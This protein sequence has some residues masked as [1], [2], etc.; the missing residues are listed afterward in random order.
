MP[1]SSDGASIISEI[2]QIVKWIVIANTGLHRRNPERYARNLRE[3]DKLLQIVML[4]STTRYLNVRRTLSKSRTHLYRLPHLE[5]DHFIQEVRV[6][7]RTFACILAWLE[8]DPIFQNNSLNKQRPV[9]VQLACALHRLGHNGTGASLGMTARAMGISY[10][11]VVLYTQ[12]VIIATN[13]MSS[14]FLTWPDATERRSLALLSHERFGF[15]GCIGLSTDGTHIP[16]YQRPGLDGETYF[17]RKKCYSLNV[18]LTFDMHRSIRFVIAGWPGSVHDTRPW[19]SSDVF[20]YPHLYFDEGQFQLCD[21]AFTLNKQTLIPF[22]NPAAQEAHNAE[23]NEIL[24]GQRVVSEHGNGILKGRWSSLKNLPILM[25]SEKDVQRSCDWITC[26][27]ILHNMVTSLNRKEDDV[28]YELQNDERTMQA[29]A[30]AFDNQIHANR[31]EDLD[32]TQWRADIQRTLL[33][34]RGWIY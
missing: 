29:E 1:R 21:S 19:E 23:F 32:S 6:C 15:T 33:T 24:C 28:E 31:Q 17:N 12:R 9:W 34:S 7:K 26:C 27:C 2:D 30:L 14:Q 25:N 18:M 20:L 3:I 4:I 22:R 11:T 13:N 5:V 16:L 10:G 8:V